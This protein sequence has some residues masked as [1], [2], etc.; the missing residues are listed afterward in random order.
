MV[1][2]YIFIAT[3]LSI[4]SRTVSVRTVIHL[5][6][7]NLSCTSKRIFL[8]I[9]SLCGLLCR[10]IEDRTC[11]L[12]QA[13][14][15]GWFICHQNTLLRL[16]SCLVIKNKLLCNV[17][18][19]INIQTYGSASPKH[20]QDRAKPDANT[21]TTICCGFFKTLLLDICSGSGSIDQWCEFTVLCIYT[22]DNSPRVCKKQYYAIGL[23]LCNLQI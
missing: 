7:L 17:L 18:H 5:A 10:H 21:L 14:V 20:T 13:K 6:Q 9:H 8:P 2:Q 11:R 15:D 23:S 19:L 3:M 22:W 1:I 16:K 12:Q 4:A